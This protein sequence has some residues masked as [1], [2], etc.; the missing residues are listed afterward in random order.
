M[1]RVTYLQ[2]LRANRGHVRDTQHKA[3]RVQN[4]GFAATVQAGDG[5]EALV[6]VRSLVTVWVDGVASCLPSRDD[7]PHGVRLEAL[8][9]G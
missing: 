7:G 5:I 9:N 6:P 1:R 4:I 2:V 3:Y 8:R